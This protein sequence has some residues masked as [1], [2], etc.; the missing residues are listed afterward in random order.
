V[1]AWT[2]GAG[3]LSLA[4]VTAPRLQPRGQA[5]RELAGYA[6]ILAFQGSLLLLAFVCSRLHRWLLE[7]PRGNNPTIA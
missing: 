6:E 5:A 7:P 4:A 2:G 1:L 3:I